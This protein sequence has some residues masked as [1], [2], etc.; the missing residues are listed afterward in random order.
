MAE[1]KT[2]PT[3]GSVSSFINAVADETRRADAKQLVKLMQS[4]TGEKPAMWGPSIIGFGTHHYV[5]D[6][7]REGDM[8][9]VGFSPRKPAQVLYALTGSPGA[10]ALLAKLG[11]FTMGKGCVYVKK[12]SDIDVKVLEKLVRAS[13]AAKKVTPKKG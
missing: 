6:S 11:K 13:V 10:E 12:L 7:G 8:P 2:K 1:N 9:L 4:V 5:H 3:K